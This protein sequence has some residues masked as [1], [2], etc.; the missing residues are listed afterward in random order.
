MAG[1][2]GTQRTVVAERLLGV[3]NGPAMQDDGVPGKD[4]LVLRD[5]L[6]QVLFD[7]DRI[8]F[9]GQAQPESQ[10]L[11]VRVHHESVRFAE[12][13]AQ[14]HIGGLSGHTRKA[15]QV[16]HRV[17]DM[18]VVLVDQQVGRANHILC[19]V[20]EEPR[21]ADLLHERVHVGVGK[22]LHRRIGIEQGFRHLVDVHIRGLCG[23][24]GGKQ[25]FV[26]VA[27]VQGTVGIRVVLVEHGQDAGY[28][29]VSGHECCV[30]LSTH[31]GPAA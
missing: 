17:R 25:Q 16:L 11:D 19:L 31:K 14:D 28:A 21:R 13:G 20:A 10:P 6:H 9:L 24:D 2:I 26:R 30:G 3:A 7:L 5:D 18:C 23:H 8:G 29:G 12:P 4:P 27:M 22:S 15:Q 1:T